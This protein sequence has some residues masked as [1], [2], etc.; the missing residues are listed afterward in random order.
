MY[1]P[2]YCCVEY[3]LQ[4]FTQDLLVGASGDLDFTKG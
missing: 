3:F 2:V 4:G 1:N